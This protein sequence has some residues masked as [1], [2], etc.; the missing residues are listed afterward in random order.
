MGFS[1][2]H[3]MDAGEVVFTQTSQSLKDRAK[4]MPI[5]KCHAVEASS[6]S[7]N[8]LGPP[9]KH[10]LSKSDNGCCAPRTA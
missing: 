4:A 8:V 10:L 1:R 5:T 7:F 9:L 6:C 3:D 2:S